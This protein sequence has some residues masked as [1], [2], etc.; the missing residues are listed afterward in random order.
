MLQQRNEKQFEITGESDSSA[1][2]MTHLFQPSM[3]DDTEEHSEQLNN[4]KLLLQRSFD[5]DI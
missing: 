3:L 2:F 4:L 5:N 1:Q